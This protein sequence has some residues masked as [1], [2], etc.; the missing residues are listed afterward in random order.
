MQ[1]LWFQESSLAVGCVSV[2]LLPPALITEIA[3]PKYRAIGTSFFNSMLYL[4]DVIAG[5]IIYS[6]H[7][8]SRH[9]SWRIT[10]IAQLIF[11]ICHIAF[12]HFTPESPRYLVSVG[13]IDE[14]RKIL[15]EFH[16][17]N[18]KVLGGPLVDFELKEI[19]ATINKEQETESSSFKTFFRTRGNI[20]RF[21]ICCFMGYAQYSIGLFAIAYHLNP[22]LETAG[23]TSTDTKLLVAACLAI[24]SLVTSFV[25]SLVIDICGRRKLFL[26]NFMILLVIYIIYTIMSAYNQKL[27]YGNSSL[28]KA[29]LG[30]I[31]LAFIPYNVGFM[32]LPFVYLTEILPFSLRS[33]GLLVFMISTQFTVIF[34]GFVT[35]VAMDAISW[36]FYIVYCC[37]IGLC[38]VI[39]F[40]F[41]PETRGHSLEK[42]GL[43]FGDNIDFDE[44]LEGRGSEESEDDIIKKQET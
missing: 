26:G 39:I 27:N 1:A 9:W 28:A 4:G 29:I 18:H 10:V 44:P 16:G 5:R 25:A 37:S 35:P 40:F 12:L 17:G 43:V 42:V 19:R 30:L 20:L 33:R 15:M 14:A 34:N 38:A 22:V 23:I 31:F 3:Y 36:R 21:F 32:D 8:M 6:A 24:F 2:L 13:R 41:F 11:P 7:F